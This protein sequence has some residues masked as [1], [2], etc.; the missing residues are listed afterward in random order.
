[1]NVPP[2]CDDLGSPER[3][4]DLHACRPDRGKESPSQTHEKGKHDSSEGDSGSEGETEGEL[5]ER[6]EVHH[7]DRDELHEGGEE[8]TAT[9]SDE[10][11][12]EGLQ[13]KGGEDAVRWKP[14]A[15]RVPISVVLVATAAYMVIMA[16]MI[17]PREKMMVRA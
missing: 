10:T 9:A 3:I 16:P 6:L 2:S 8:D 4:D 15:R 7:R 11:E 12:K 1:M 17:A 14:R 5:R 13:E